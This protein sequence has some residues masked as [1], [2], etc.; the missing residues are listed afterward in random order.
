LSAAGGVGAL[1]GCHDGQDGF[2]K[3]RRRK[4]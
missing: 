4:L 3:P 2:D 1:C